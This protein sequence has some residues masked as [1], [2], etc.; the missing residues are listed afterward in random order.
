MTVFGAG[1]PDGFRDERRADDDGRDDGEHGGLP[2][3]VQANDA[4]EPEPVAPCIAALA[5]RELG[6]DEVRDLLFGFRRRVIRG[7]A[8]RGCCLP[9]R[10]GK[11][12][13]E[14]IR[15]FG[16]DGRWRRFNLRNGRGRRCRNSQRRLH[17]I[18]M[19]E[20]CGEF[21]MVGAQLGQMSSKRRSALGQQPVLEHAFSSHD[22]LGGVIGE[23]P[24]AWLD[25]T[26]DDTGELALL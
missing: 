16:N 4:K 1:E 22:V 3:A 26:R 21:L 13:G 20:R 17:H 25:G 15:R 2:A 9:R 18:D 11:L 14:D 8:L 7:G 10:P 5:Q 23:Q 12:W 24:V 19:D 6:G